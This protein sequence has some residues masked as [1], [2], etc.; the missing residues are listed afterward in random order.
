MYAIQKLPLPL[1]ST[2]SYVNPLMALV[3]GWLVLAERLGWREGAAALVILLGVA[4]VK[5]SPKEIR[6]LITR[7]RGG[8]SATP[9]EDCRTQVTRSAA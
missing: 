6:L 4:L 7:V 5:T 2:Y 1:V 3:L 9:R 8:Q